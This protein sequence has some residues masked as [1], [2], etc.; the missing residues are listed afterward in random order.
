M[1]PAGPERIALQPENSS[2]EHN[3]PSDFII[4][5]SLKLVFFLINTYGFRIGKAR[6]KTREILSDDWV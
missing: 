6:K 5:S 1:P 4:R 3:P 2:E